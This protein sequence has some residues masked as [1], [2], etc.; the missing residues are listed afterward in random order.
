[1]K[2]WQKLIVFLLIIVFF[3]LGFRLGQQVEKTNKKIDF[4]LSITP[5]KK[6]SPTPT[7]SFTE[8]KINRYVNKINH[9]K[10]LEI[11]Q[12]TNASEIIINLKND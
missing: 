2:N 8:T 11:K 5:T 7:L 9:P 12:S 6:P 4:L 10:N 1:M 3:I